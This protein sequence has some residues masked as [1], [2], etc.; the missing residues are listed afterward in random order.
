MGRTVAP[1]S[2]WCR[3]WSNAWVWTAQIRE[4]VGIKT[5]WTE[6]LEY[7]DLPAFDPFLIVFLFPGSFFSKN[8]SVVFERTH[9]CLHWVWWR[10]HGKLDD[11][12]SEPWCYWR[13]CFLL[14]RFLSFLTC[15]LWKSPL[16][17]L[18]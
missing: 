2:L 11:S 17:R 13:N 4:E 15:R 12:S 8:S 9:L 14:F 18:M 6:H 16:T 10:N 5:E 3:D 1:E 7:V